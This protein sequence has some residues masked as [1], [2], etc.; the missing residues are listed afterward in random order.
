MKNTLGNNGESMFDNLGRIKIVDGMRYYK[1]TNDENNMTRVFIELKKQ[2]DP[3]ALLYAFEKALKRHRVFRFIVVSDDKYFYLKENDEKPV[4]HLNTGD[5]YVVGGDENNGYLTRIGYN[6]NTITIDIFHGVTDGMGCTAFQRT[7]LYYY[8]KK[9]G[10]EN[11]DS[12]GILLENDAEDVCEFTE[13]VHFVPKEMVEISKGYEYDLAF[14]LGDKHI[15]SKYACKVYE[16]KVD[17]SEFESYMRANSSSRSGVFTCFMNSVIAENNDIGELPIVAALAVN[18]RPALGAEKTNMC[19]V[20]TVPVW[21]DNDIKKLP[22]GEQMKLSRQMIVDGVEKN[23]IIA[24]VQRSV[25]FNKMMEEQCETL[26][27]KKQFARIANERGGVKYTYGLSYVGEI[28]Y[29]NGI[30]EHVLKNYPQLC[31]NTIPIIMEI[32]KYAGSYYIIYCSHLE[33]DPYV[34]KLQE[35]FIKAGIS[36]QIQQ[37][38]DFYET[39]AI[40]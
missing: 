39:L 18:A 20:A 36:C 26:E 27:Q 23:K 15:E 5:R 2:V 37:K 29:G 9:I 34:Y 13:C 21:Y 33:H 19:C 1:K 4:I 32:V 17:A 28:K 11:I 7:L 16:L 6:G 8:M 12:T 40:F 3:D 24:T 14:Q 25:A 31:A 38:D 35:K 10:V 22:E 30:D